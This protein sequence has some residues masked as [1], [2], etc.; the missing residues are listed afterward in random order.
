MKYY[1][2]LFLILFLLFLLSCG[3]RKSPTGGKKDTENPTIVSILPDEFFDINNRDIEVVFSKPID[4]SSILSG[5]YICP[6]ILNKKFKWDKN[7][8]IIKI[9]EDLE[10]NT[11]YFFTFSRRIKGEHNNKNQGKVSSRYQYSGFI[12]NPRLFHRR[13]CSQIGQHS[14]PPVKSGESTSW[15][16]KQKSLVYCMAPR[17]R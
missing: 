9:L 1:T 3:H 13:T 4:R 16:L 7:T 8:L 10:Q 12:T 2:K 14:L 15:I 17:L 6:P 5:I 11:N